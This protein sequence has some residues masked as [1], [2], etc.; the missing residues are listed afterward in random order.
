MVR[1]W[2]LM[3]GLVLLLI[4]LSTAVEASSPPVGFLK[5]KV[6]A[7][8][9]LN[10][11]PIG[12]DVSL[13]E[14]VEK[15]YK[16]GKWQEIEKDT[17][18]YN[19]VSDDKITGLKGAVNS[20]FRLKI[21]DNTQVVVLSRVV[22]N[23]NDLSQNEICQYF[24][25]I[26]YN[27][28]S[29]R[30]TRELEDNKKS[31]QKIKQKGLNFNNKVNNYPGVYETEDGNVFKKLVVQSL[32]LSE[33]KFSIYTYYK[34]KDLRISSDDDKNSYDLICK[35]ENIVTS[36]NV[37][38]AEFDNIL[39]TAIIDDPDCTIKL[40]TPDDLTSD[41]FI[42]V[43]FKGTCKKF[44]KDYDG[45]SKGIFEL[46]DNTADEDSSFFYFSGRYVKRGPVT[47]PVINSDGWK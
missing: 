19:V 12:G 20:V 18:S 41:H 17:W 30:K 36:T 1:K 8:T 10:G 4:S 24:M 35:M 34:P 31:E 47:N 6:Y 23:K 33:I 37:K 13:Q 14:F 28:P 22:V 5:H 21:L 42:T 16:K 46:K 15:G 9:P 2:N 26:Y 38:D 29:K 32:S 11:G 39:M 25:N 27:L 44:C 43:K 3:S 40:E 45:L 7:I